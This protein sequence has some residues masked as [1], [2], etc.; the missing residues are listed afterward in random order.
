MTMRFIRILDYLS[1]SPF[2][3]LSLY[4]ISVQFIEKGKGR[5]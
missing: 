2:I 4:E 5:I 1:F 3:L